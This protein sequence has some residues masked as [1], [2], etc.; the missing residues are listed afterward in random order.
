MTVHDGA[1]AELTEPHRLR[2]RS[3]GL[4]RV[5]RRL[6][7]DGGLPGRGLDHEPSVP[8]CFGTDPIVRASRTRPTPFAMYSRDRAT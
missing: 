6:T 3:N 2:L 1:A 5:E 4:V 7:I 8:E